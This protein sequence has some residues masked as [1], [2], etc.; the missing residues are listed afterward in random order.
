MNVPC[1]ASE[2]RTRMR[3]SAARRIAVHETAR[4][5]IEPHMIARP[6]STSVGLAVIRAAAMF[7]KPIF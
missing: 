6:S 7:V 1:A 4:S 3:G 5:T 2:N